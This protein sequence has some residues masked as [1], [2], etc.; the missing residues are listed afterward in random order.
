MPEPHTTEPCPDCSG[1]PW[2]DKP[3]PHWSEGCSTCAGR[4]TFMVIV[5]EDD[6]E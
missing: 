2:P 6:D 1:N 3:S 4:G 5:F